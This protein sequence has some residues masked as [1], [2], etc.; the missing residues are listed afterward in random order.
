MR[1]IFVVLLIF[2]M[3]AVSGAAFADSVG[4]ATSPG[5]HMASVGSIG[6]SVLAFSPKDGTI[7]VT[8]NFT[9]CDGV[10]GV[11]DL[12]VHF[13]ANLTSIMFEPGDAEDCTISGNGTQTA[14]LTCAAGTFFGVGDKISFSA[15]A[16][17]GTKFV[18]A[19]WSTSAAC[20][21]ATPVPEPGVPLLVGTGVASMAGIIRRKLRM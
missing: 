8:E 1:P 2:G 5:G 18:S 6:S 14:T 15:M 17:E 9:C 20:N 7:T 10:A 19:C 3:A 12:Q 16:P 21:P 4:I 13:S 11:T